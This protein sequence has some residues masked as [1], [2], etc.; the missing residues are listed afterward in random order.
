MAEKQK[1]KKNILRIGQRP[2]I[3]VGIFLIIVFYLICF[4]VMYLTRKHVQVYEVNTGSVAYTSTFT[5]I[6]VRE[7]MVVN[8]NYSGTFNIYQHEGNRVKAGDIVCTVDESGKVAEALSQYTSSAGEQLNSDDIRAMITSINAYKTNFSSEGLSGLSSLKSNLNSVILGAVTSE[9]EANLD[10][11][12]AF[13]GQAGSFQSLTADQAGYVVYET[14]GCESLD[15]SN[16]TAESFDQS[17][18]AEQRTE[19]NESISAGDPA[20]KL[21]TSENW[22]ILI[23]LS[24]SQISANGLQNKT[25]VTVDFLE[26]NI[27]TTANFQIITKDGLNYGKITLN[28]YVVRYCTDR[29]INIRLVTTRPDGLKI[30]VSAVVQQSYYAIPSEYVT[31][32]GPDGSNGFIAET[33]DSTGGTV[34]TFVS[35]NILSDPKDSS[36]VYVSRN[37]LTEGISLLAPDS[38]SRYVIGPTGTVNGVYCINTGYTVFVPIYIIDSSDEYVIASTTYGGLSNYD[39]I[40]L[41]AKDF[42]ENELIY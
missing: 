38:D 12:L 42:S 10:S 36:T 29:F 23:Q 24:N 6:A 41:T 8:S 28:K 15:D 33:T 22:Y 2:K 30:P 7:E 39:R 1:T 17:S 26:D 14:D 13:S 16:F 31:Q 25:S 11:I 3:A 37:E 20:Y 32:G 21:I 34:Q 4:T 5:G 18:Y 40:V 9:I 27:S 19:N 35:P